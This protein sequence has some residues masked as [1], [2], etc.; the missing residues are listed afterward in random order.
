MAALRERVSRAEPLEA[1]GARV[2][3]RRDAGQRARLDQLKA[4]LKQARIDDP[5]DP[6]GD[7]DGG[8]GH[9]ALDRHHAAARRAL[10]AGRVRAD[11]L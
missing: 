4:R 5:N 10:P 9:E 6:G 7:R 1:L 8:G 11:A 2:G 3:E